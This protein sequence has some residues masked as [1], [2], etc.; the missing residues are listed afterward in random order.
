MSG[1]KTKRYLLFCYLLVQSAKGAIVVTMFVWKHSCHTAFKFFKCLLT[2]S[3]S[4]LG[5]GCLRWSS[6]RT[7]TLVYAGRGGVVLVVT[8]QIAFKF[9]TGVLIT[10]EV[11]ESPH[12]LQC[13]G[14]L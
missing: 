2:E 4:Y 1:A 11:T 10:Y 13:P 8:C 9:G 5:H 14:L 12:G 7:D 6:R 3:I